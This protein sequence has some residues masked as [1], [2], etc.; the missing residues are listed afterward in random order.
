[1]SVEVPA[2]VKTAIIIAIMRVKRPTIALPLHIALSL[3]TH[4]HTRLT[5]LFRV[6]VAS[7]GPAKKP[8]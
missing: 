5:A 7:A 4:T 2:V 3:H 1:V 8:G 6:A